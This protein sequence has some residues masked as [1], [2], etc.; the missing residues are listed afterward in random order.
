VIRSF[1]VYGP[2]TACLLVACSVDTSALTPDA[3]A[4]VVTDSAVEVRDGTLDAADT[5][6]PDAEMRDADA[7]DGTGHDAGTDTIT[8]DAGSSF[9]ESGDPLL[10]VRFEDS[11]AD[12]SAA[13]H[14]MRES[15]LTYADGRAGRAGVF[16]PGM[17]AWIEQDGDLTGEP[18]TVELFL[19]P[20]A[21]PDSGRMGVWDIGGQHS[22]WV[23]DGASFSCRSIRVDAALSIDT[24]THVACV[25]DGDSS[26]AYVDG[27]LAATGSSSPGTPGP[28]DIRIGADNPDGDYFEGLIDEMR[29]FRGVRSPADIAAAAAR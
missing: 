20:S 19:K 12:E 23:R 27:V 6:V 15:G 11:L 26:M 21:L 16:G 5:Q 2:L 28:G 25:F 13:A 18:L 4:R 1:A 9:C 22:A 29:I 14:T 8:P 17:E 3:D 10:C 24:W 7:T